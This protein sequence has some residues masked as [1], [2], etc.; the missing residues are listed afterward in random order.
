MSC[1]LPLISNYEVNL[2]QYVKLWFFFFF[3]KNAMS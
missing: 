3:L 2:T 1:E